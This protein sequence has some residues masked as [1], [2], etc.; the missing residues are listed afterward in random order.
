MDGLYDEVIYV[1]IRNEQKNRK[2][3]KKKLTGENY[4]T[5]R[6][7]DPPTVVGHF[8]SGKLHI[9]AFETQQ[10]INATIHIY[11]YI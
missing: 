1:Y 8:R 2:I 7:G 4:H 10:L 11:I 6:R 3:K 5:G 9:D